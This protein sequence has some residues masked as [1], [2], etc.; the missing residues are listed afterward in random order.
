MLRALNPLSADFSRALPL[1]FK[2]IVKTGASFGM[3][4]LVQKILN[5][6][7]TAQENNAKPETVQFVNDRVRWIP[8]PNIVN[9]GTIVSVALLR[10][11]NFPSLSSAAATIGMLAGA[12]ELV[13]SGITWLEAQLMDAPEEKALYKEIKTLIQQ[14]LSH[15]RISVFAGMA[16]LA[17]RTAGSVAGQNPLITLGTSGMIASTVATVGLF[18][19]TVIEVKACEKFEKE[20][21]KTRP[22]IL[23]SV[24]QGASLG[25]TALVAGAVG[26]ILKHRGHSFQGSLAHWAALLLTTGAASL[27]VS[28]KL[29]LAFER[30]DKTEWTELVKDHLLTFVKAMEALILAV[31]GVL[32]ANKALQNLGSVYFLSARSLKIAFSILAIGSI[33]GAAYLAVEILKEELQTSKGKTEQDNVKL[34][35]LKQLANARFKWFQVIHSLMLGSTAV[36]TTGHLLGVARLN[37][38]SSRNTAVLVIVDAILVYKTSEEIKKS[39]EDV[40]FAEVKPNQVKADAVDDTEKN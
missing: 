31:P 29:R 30:A 40:T 2:I 21:P 10:F 27:F 28:T 25:L 9:L 7:G 6:A 19:L 4:I 36:W 12:E 20:D 34:Q 13:F 22:L 38:W 5:Y 37:F 23:K 1:D 11:Y 18:V 35:N 15:L 39:L 33:G 32:I 16:F 26:F 14:R 3:Q 8:K 17:L 24:T